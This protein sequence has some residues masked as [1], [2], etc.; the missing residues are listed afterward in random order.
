MNS[1]NLCKQCFHLQEME[2]AATKIQSNYRGY[3]TRKRIKVQRTDADSVCVSRLLDA[4]ILN[5]FRSGHCNKKTFSIVLVMLHQ[6]GSR[7]SWGDTYVGFCQCNEEEE[8]VNIKKYI[9]Q[10]KNNVS[11]ANV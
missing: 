7:T 3:K 10:N 1:A 8:W 4:N 2:N 9:F 11:L 5:S 6:I